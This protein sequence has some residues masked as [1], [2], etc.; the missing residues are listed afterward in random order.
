MGS[1]SNTSAQAPQQPPTAI[2]P[3]VFQTQEPATPAQEMRKLVR[4]ISK[5]ARKFNSKFSI[6]TSGGL[7]ILEKEDAVDTTKKSPASTYMRSIDGINIQGLNFHP[8]QEGKGQNKIN[9]EKKIHTNMVRLANIA[10]RRGLK[11]FVTDF[12][13]NVKMIQESYNLN[14]AKGFV[15]FTAKNAGA[16]YIFNA[17]PTTPFRPVNEN[18]KNIVGL[19][20]V[21]NYLYLIDSSEFDRQQDF[22]IA[23]GNTN[24]DAVVVDVFH[25]GRK[26]FSKAAIRGMKFKKLGARRLVFAYMNIGVAENYRYYWKNNWIEGEP[27]FISAPNRGNPDKFFVE[28]WRPGWRNIITGNTKSYIYGIVTQGFDGVILD[29]LDSFKFF[30]SGGNN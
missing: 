21:K 1:H 24:F 27:A 15:T 28:Y 7:E 18:P 17:I 30:E 19:K 25:N 10:K 3:D 14:L 13:A 20:S 26:P 29:G 16:E 22:V 12:G 8:P 5:Y 4:D 9:T 23:L 2:I 6:I 11:I